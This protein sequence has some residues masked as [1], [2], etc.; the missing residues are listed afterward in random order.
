MEVVRK[1]RSAA[2]MR[3][4][5]GSIA[6]PLRSQ[7]PRQNVRHH[8]ILFFVGRDATPVACEEVVMRKRHRKGNGQC[9]PR[10]TVTALHGGLAAIN[11]LKFTTGL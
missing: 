2:P 8:S 9:R 6:I 7:N 11:R 10:P 3:A 5:D 1:S 4:T